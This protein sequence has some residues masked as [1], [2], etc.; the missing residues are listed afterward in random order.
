LHAKTFAVDHSRIFVGSFNFDQRSARLNTEM[1]LVIDSPTLARQLA[2]R[3]DTAAPVGA[4]EVR[5]GSDGR[6]L[7][8]IERTAVG[9]TRYDTEPGTTWFQRR[10]VDFYSI[11]PIDW[12]L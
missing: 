7:E 12:M 8:W 5:L 4:Y 2:E 1:G 10:S 9:E 6:T 3:F 11:L